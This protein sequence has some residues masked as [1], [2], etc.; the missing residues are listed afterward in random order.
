[1]S[2]GSFVIDFP[3]VTLPYVS[4]TAIVKQKMLDYM[5]VSWDPIWLLFGL[6]H[7]GLT[8]RTAD[9]VPGLTYTT[10]FLVL[11]YFFKISHYRL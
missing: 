4:S 10:G 3:L 9:F 5:E 1:M 8:H 7:S 6:S 2:L 11:F